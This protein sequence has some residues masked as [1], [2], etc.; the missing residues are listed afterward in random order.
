MAHNLNLLPMK[1][2]S[3]KKGSSKILLITIAYTLATFLGMACQ[4]MSASEYICRLTE[5]GRLV[6]RPSGFCIG[7]YG[8]LWIESMQ[9]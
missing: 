1:V 5:K 3:R 9:Y 4:K 6:K 7:L 2:Y 8:F